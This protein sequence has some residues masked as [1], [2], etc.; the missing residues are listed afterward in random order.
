MDCVSYMNLHSKVTRGGGLVS[1]KR[2][3]E[4]CLDCRTFI[5][6][7]N[8]DGSNVLIFFV[9]QSFKRSSKALKWP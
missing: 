8:L 5:H 3:K 6:S 7:V 1:F 9:K 4:C 2:K